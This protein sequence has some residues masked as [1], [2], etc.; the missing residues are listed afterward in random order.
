MCIIYNIICMMINIFL[1][2]LERDFFLHHC[3]D[4]ISMVA[5]QRTKNIRNNDPE[6]QWPLRSQQI[7]NPH[8]FLRLQCQN[9]NFR[10]MPC[11]VH[12]I[13]LLKIFNGVICADLT[14]SRVTMLT[15]CCGTASCS[16]PSLSYLHY[17]DLHVQAD[18]TV[19]IK[20][21]KL[22]VIAPAG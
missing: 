2:F 9:P 10:L 22:M 5:E 14:D 8:I 21:N 20:Q 16:I 4:I 15:A 3:D 17:I 1:Y 19:N 12:A 7:R 11:Q 18:N 6:D 13:L